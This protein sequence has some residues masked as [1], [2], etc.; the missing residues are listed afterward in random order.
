MGESVF[1][2]KTAIW[3]L[4]DASGPMDATNKTTTMSTAFGKQG[5][6]SFL[7]HCEFLENAY[8][9]LQSDRQSSLSS[10]PEEEQFQMG[11]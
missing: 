6:T 8:S 4:S 7:R 1:R 5:N 11:P 3:T 2:K 10:D 9:K